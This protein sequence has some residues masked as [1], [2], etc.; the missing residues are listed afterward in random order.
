M[1]ISAIPAFTSE[2]IREHG[3]TPD[4]YEKINSCWAVANLLVPS[5]ASS[6]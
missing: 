2:T 4:E 5:L 6:A 3:L 1:T